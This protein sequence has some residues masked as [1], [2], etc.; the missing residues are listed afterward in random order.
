MNYIDF[1]NYLTDNKIRFLNKKLNEIV[2]SYNFYYIS[3]NLSID[4]NQIYQNFEKSKIVIINQYEDKYSK[5]KAKYFLIGFEKT[6]II[7]NQSSS[8]FIQ[9]LLM[10]NSELNICF[11]SNTKSV[12]DDKFRIE[13]TEIEYETTFKNEISV[14]QNLSLIDSHDLDRI[15][16]WKCIQ[17]C[18]FGYLI[19]QSYFKKR[20]SRIKLFFY[21]I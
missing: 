17:H 2:K 16:I 9:S 19:K 12:F 21:K 4:Q 6:I 10:N 15:Q 20:K 18:I 14:F 7:I 11:I 1:N 13:Y 5:T 3:G 8:D